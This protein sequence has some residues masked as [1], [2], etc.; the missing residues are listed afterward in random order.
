[1]KCNPCRDCG[2]CWPP[3][4]NRGIIPCLE[5]VKDCQDRAGDMEADGP[6][7]EHPDRA[8][9]ERKGHSS[10]TV[11]DCIRGHLLQEKSGGIV[12]TVRGLFWLKGE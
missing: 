4:L 3:R 9:L 1:M 7:P 5:A 2:D 10:A 12:L 8:W 6:V 11:E